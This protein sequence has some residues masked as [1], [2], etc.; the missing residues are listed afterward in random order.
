MSLIRRIG[1][2]G[3]MVDDLQI[4]PPRLDEVYSHYMNQESA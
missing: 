3:E 1:D 2:L 4:K